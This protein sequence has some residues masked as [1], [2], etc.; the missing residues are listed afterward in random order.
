M[1]EELHCS[2]FEDRAI[3]YAAGDLIEDERA[4]VEAHARR[5][6]TCAAVLSHEISLRRAIAARVQPADTLDRSELLLARCRSELFEALDYA[7]AQPKRTWRAL[8][9]PWRLVG[10]FRHT[11]VFH[12]GWSAAAL[13]LVGA[14]ASTAAREWYRQIALPVPR[15]PV[16]TVLAP[17]PLTDRELRPIDRDGFRFDQKTV[18]PNP[19]AEL[20]VRTARPRVVQ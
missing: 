9:T 8:V 12:P 10:A 18:P 4:A 1:V 16:I 11:F 3:L 7:A 5:C 19:N 20:Q 15:N 17:A 13:L 6:A 2:N 14:L